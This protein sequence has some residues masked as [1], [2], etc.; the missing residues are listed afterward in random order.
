MKK[1]TAR[2]LK[3]AKETLVNLGV[4]SLGRVVG[5]MPDTSDTC[6]TYAACSFAPECYTRVLSACAIC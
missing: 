1:H 3:L 6:D 5:G 2:K 4:R